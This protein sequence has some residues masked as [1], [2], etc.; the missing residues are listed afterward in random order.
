[1]KK[2]F[3]MLLALSMVFN[4]SISTFALHEDETNIENVSG[5]I[6]DSVVSVNPVYEGLVSEE[7]LVGEAEG[8]SSYAAANYVDSLE[9][10]GEILREQL[11]ERKNPVIVYYIADEYDQQLF[12]DLINAAY[13][14]TGDPTEGDYIRFNNIGWHGSVN[15]KNSNGAYYFTFT[16]TM[17]YCATAE[18]EK[19]VDKKVDSVIAGLKLAGKNQYEKVCAIYDYICE[20]VT[21]DYEN[22]NDDSY[23]LKFSTYAALI[24][25]T[26]VCQGYATLFYRLALEAGID[27]RVITG[28]GNGG[29]HAWNVVELSKLYYNLDSTWD[30]GSENYRYF[31]RSNDNFDDH[32]RDSEYE[33]KQFNKSY[34]MGETDYDPSKAESDIIDSGHCGGESGGTNIMWEIDKYG[35]L[36]LTGEGATSS[37]APNGN[38]RWLEYKDIITGLV[39]GEG[40]THIGDCAFMGLENLSG[41]VELPKSLVSI[42]NSAFRGCDKLSGGL[43]IPENVTEIGHFAFYECESLDGKL[44]LNEGLNTIGNYSFSGC[45]GFEESLDVPSS[46]TKIGGYAFYN[47]SINEYNFVGDAPEVGAASGDMPSF[48][49]DDTIHYP[50]DNETWNTAGGKWNGFNAKGFGEVKNATLTIESAEIS[51]GNS[52]TVSVSISEGSNASMI[53]FALKYDSDVLEVAACK[54]EGLFEDA[55]INTNEKGLIIFAWDSLDAVEE[56]GKLISIEFR[57]KDGV[58]AKETAIEVDMTE[59]FIFADSDYKDI[60]VEIIIGKISII[61]IIYGDLND[62]GKINVIDANMVRRA[63]ARLIELDETHEKAADVS[64][65]GKVNVIDANVVR[66]YA[67]KLIDSFPVGSGHT[68]SYSEEIT[69]KEATCVEEGIVSSTCTECGE[70]V[71][72]TIP[73]LGHDYSEEVT[74]KATCTD[75]GVITYTCTRCDDSYTETTTPTGHSWKEADCVSP[76]SCEECGEQEGEALGHDYVGG[77]CT[78]P[79]E[80]SRCGEK[81]T[82]PGHNFEDGFCTECDAL[83]PDVWLSE[84]ELYSIAS[85]FSDLVDYAIAAEDFS[86][87]AVDYY[88]RGYSSSAKSSAEDAQYYGLYVREYILSVYEMLGDFDCSYNFDGMWLS[89]KECLAEAYY[90]YEDAIAV[91]L[92]TVS[93]VYE[94]EEYILYGNSFLAGAQE[95]IYFMIENGIYV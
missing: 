17:T 15:G 9:E 37:F 34:P 58:K 27:S 61:D 50:A 39:I 45:T 69:E 55:A 2:F 52:E 25:E 70:K 67:A 33:T 66:R 44:V 19:E 56:A 65:D 90:Y 60:N 1:M 4:M 32:Y 77:N 23:I 79:G 12:T 14:H 59:T 53:Q 82:E 46:V 21:Y 80:C 64:G 24:D 62:D 10:A 20:N 35:V 83:D 30:A 95:I 28:I 88:E 36:T 7:D 49:E 68:H 38:S 57:V 11:K 84:S 26:A 3:A 51:V 6:E 93:N 29:N 63:A 8:V 42:G 54:G 75:G 94:V 85:E 89:L 5:I 76:R 18:Q 31:L 16:Y 78:T 74:L 87:E 81:G 91:D 47:C 73:A 71:T 41:T 40:I 48:D 86:S 92:G 72:K 43:V 13:V 22:L